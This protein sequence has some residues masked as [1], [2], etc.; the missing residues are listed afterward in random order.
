MY[1]HGVVA[2]DLGLAEEASEAFQLALNHPATERLKRLRLAEVEIEA[3][4]AEAVLELDREVGIADPDAMEVHLGRGVALDKSRAGSQGCRSTAAGGGLRTGLPAL[5]YQPAMVLRRIGQ[6]DEAAR[7]Q[8]R[9]E[10]TPCERHRPYSDPFMRQFKRLCEGSYLHHL[11][12]GI[13][14]EA[15]G[16]LTAAEREYLLAIE[17]DPNQP[18]ARAN[19]AGVYG[20]LERY[21]H[22][23]AAYRSISEASLD[24][25]EAHYNYGVVLSQ[26]ESIGG[27]KAPTAES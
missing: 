22:A 9:Y 21:V 15:A 1:L 24:I 16:K 13:D 12:R 20:K 8:T 7:F 18:H 11:D 23:D 27:Q 25:E 19:F 10:R 14:P 26:P 3:E 2:E 6:R 4:R 17:A 5:H